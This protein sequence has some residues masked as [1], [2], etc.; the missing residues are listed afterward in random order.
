MEI[1]LKCVLI[2]NFFITG[3][4]MSSVGI[5]I[6]QA[7]HHYGVT[8]TQASFLFIYKEVTIIIS[9]FLLA[10]LLQRLGSKKAMLVP[11]FLIAIGCLA[12]PLVNTFWMSKVLF[13]L[14]GFSFMLIK[15]TTY[16]LARLYTNTDSQYS[17][18]INMIEGLF[19]LGVLFGSFLFSFF[20]HH[21][22]QE[23]AGWLNTYWILSLCASLS[24]VLIIFTHIDECNPL[25]KTTIL[26][27]I[28]PLLS[29][30][31]RGIIWIFIPS[32]FIYMLIE[33]AISVWLPTLYHHTFAISPGI[34]VLLASILFIAIAAG[35]FF[36]G[37]IMRYMHWMSVLLM[38]MIFAIVLIFMIVLMMQYPAYFNLTLWQMPIVVLLIPLLGFFIGPVYP[39]LCASLFMKLQ[40][41]EHSRMMAWVIIFSSLGSIAGTRSM[42]IMIEKMGGIFAMSMLMP[43]TVLLLMILLCHRF[44]YTSK[45]TE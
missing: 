45:N 22:T 40:S 28:K 9:S 16:T 20:I 21:S 7:I 13:V 8:Q 15:S 38:V 5:V 29:L 34:S 3:A 41:H 44:I 18:F 14:T 26:K 11:V 33:Q 10:V 37:F 31:K 36:W 1:K 30:L 24:F 39:T 19:I 4:L 2:L 42:G 43:M 25:E 32:M 27:E 23:G 35:R 12:M 17:S 6:L